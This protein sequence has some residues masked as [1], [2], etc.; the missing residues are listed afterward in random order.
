MKSEKLRKVF[1]EIDTA[2]SRIYML[3]QYMKN[4][5]HF[6]KI[7]N[8]ILQDLGMMTEDGVFIPQNLDDG[9]S[10]A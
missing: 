4:D 3:N 5:V 1:Q 9:P 8:M 10:N 7:I 2:S 6:I